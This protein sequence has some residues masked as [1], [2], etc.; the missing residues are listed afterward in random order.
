MIADVI[1]GTQSLRDEFALVF[2]K[3]TIDPPE[4]YENLIEI[5]GTSEIIDLTEVLSGDVEYKQ[6]KLKIIL[7]DISGSRLYYSHYS[8]L[9]NYL[10]GQKLKIIFTEDPSFYY[11]GRISMDSFDFQNH[12]GTITI[13][14]NV[15]PYKYEVT[16]SLEDWLWNDLSIDTIIRDYR[17]IV[18]NTTA[19]LVIT[20]RRKKVCPVFNCS[21]A[22]TVAYLGDVYNLPSG[23]SIVADI[24]LGEG[25]HTL[26]FAST[27]SATVSINYRGAML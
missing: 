20:G 2:C 16:S 10:H 13:S 27:V 14:A 22:M 4:T 17:D 23:Y 25:D 7:E 18:V 24:Y 19:T 12:G 8:K 1:I 6:R 9:A 3:K 26:L 21:V 5:P 11:F 15:D